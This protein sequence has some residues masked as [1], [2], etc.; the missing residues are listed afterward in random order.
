MYGCDPIAFSKLAQNSV[1]SVATEVTLNHDYD[2]PA[3]E[4]PPSGFNR[5]ENVS[6]LYRPLAFR[7]NPTRIPALGLALRRSV[8]FLLKPHPPA[9][10]PL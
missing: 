8:C 2:E 9:I 6:T 3:T 4:K 1:T 5:A 10:L 7:S